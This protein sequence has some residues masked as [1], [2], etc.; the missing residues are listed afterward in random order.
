MILR[1]D[2]LVLGLEEA[3][4][5]SSKAIIIHAAIWIIN[6]GATF[7]TGTRPTTNLFLGIYIVRLLSHKPI[8]NRS[9]LSLIFIPS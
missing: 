4:L 9:T 2:Q 7:N 3:A 5:F 6:I 8:P 1:I